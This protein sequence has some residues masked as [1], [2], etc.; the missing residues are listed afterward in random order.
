MLLAR[1]P[2]V[3]LPARPPTVRTHLGP[4]DGRLLEGGRDTRLASPTGRAQPPGRAAAPLQLAR[5]GS[6]RPARQPRAEGRLAIVPR[7]ATDRPR[8]ASPPRPAALDLLATT[9]RP[10][11]TGGR[12]GRA[13][14]L[15]GQG[16]PKVGL[17]AHRGRA[18]EARRAGVEDDR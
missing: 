11:A 6:G 14:L 4:P 15:P 2:L 12:G 8:L 3:P 10:A 5:P 18:E 13:H 17:P 1:G 16:E 9:S 7:N